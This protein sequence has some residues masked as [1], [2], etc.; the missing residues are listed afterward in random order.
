MK[1][2]GRVL[3]YFKLEHNAKLHLAGYIRPF[4]QARD[5]FQRR[6]SSGLLFMLIL[7]NFLFPVRNSYL[8]K[9]LSRII[10]PASSSFDIIMHVSACIRRRR[11]IFN[12]LACYY[13]T[14]NN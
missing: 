1:Q 9:P 13:T 11:L 8:K 12:T 10:A 7:F 14:C 2:K 5:K 3:L 4:E 6:K